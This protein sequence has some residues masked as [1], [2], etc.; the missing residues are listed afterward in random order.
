M[1]FNIKSKF[2]IFLIF[3]IILV[4]GTTACQKGGD[5][6]RARDASPLPPMEG[7]E[8][9]GDIERFESFVYSVKKLKENYKNVIILDAREK[10]EYG[11]GHLPGAVQAHWTDW[12]NVNAKQGEKGWAV[13]LPNE[14]LKAKLGALGIDGTKPVV[15]YNDV[16]AG[17]GEDGRQLWTLRAYG[18]KNTYILN[19]G[20]KAWTASG[21]ELVKTAPEVK[22]VNGPESASDAN[23]NADTDF[24][25][26][27]L[28][29]LKILDVR[30]DE[31]FAGLKVY[32]EKQKGRVPGAKHIWFRDFYNTDGTLQAPAQIRA[33]AESFGLNLKDEIVCYCTGGIRSGLAVIALRIA[34]FN[35]ARNYNAGYSE[36]A[37][38][39]QKVDTQVL[40]KI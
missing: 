17:W 9:P 25:S 35:S 37:G 28:A 1:K 7:R 6:L 27:R 3:T 22:A 20:I 39:G 16:F 10:G 36:W 8:L 34:G 13:M 29:S 18:L 2:R 40:K 38:T 4:Q 24:I 21:G 33:R 12:S 31:E 15:I 30:E 19:G 26:A 14:V 23:L 11:K 5:G 32:G